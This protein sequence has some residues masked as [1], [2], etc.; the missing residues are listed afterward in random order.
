[1]DRLEGTFGKFGLS[2]FFDRL[3]KSGV[4]SPGVLLELLRG[5]SLV[6]LYPMVMGV[7]AEIPVGLDQFQVA[8]TKVAELAARVPDSEYPDLADGL[9]VG[10]RPGSAQL[11]RTG[12]KGPS[13]LTLWSPRVGLRKKARFIEVADVEADD[14]TRI[15]SWRFIQILMKGDAPVIAE[16]AEISDKE[17]FLRGL[18]G[19]ARLSTL[20]LRVRVWETFQRWLVWKGL[21]PWP[22]SVGVVM[23]YL[24]YR[25]EEEPVRTFPAC[26]LAT[27]NWIELR[28]GYPQGQRLGENEGL[29]QNFA[30]AIKDAETDVVVRKKAVRF[31]L[32]VVGGME[33]AVVDESVPV[34]ARILLWVRLMK[35]YGVL[36][37]DDVQWMGPKNLTMQETGLAGILTQTKTTGAGKKVKELELFVPAEA[38]ITGKDWLKVGYGLLQAEVTF[39]RDYLIPRAT[40][41]W[42]GFYTSRATPRDMA[43]MYLGALKFVK[44]PGGAADLLGEILP[45]WSGHSERCTLTSNL[46]AMGRPKSERDVLGRWS[47]EGSDDYVRSYRA[48]VRRLVLMFV[49][50]ARCADSYKALDEDNTYAD[51]ERRLVMRHGEQEGI[52]TL[53]QNL[54]KAAKEFAVKN[55]QAD[56]VRKPDVPEEAAAQLVKELTDAHDESGDQECVEGFILAVTQK[57]KRATCLHR[58]GGCWRARSLAFRDY[59]VVE[60]GPPESHLYDRFCRVCWP[61]SD[62]RGG[63]SEASSSGTSSSSARTP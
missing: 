2:E 54:I 1:M 25:L 60:G 15:W 31:P 19:R 22:E 8:V 27:L 57:K 9:V 55:A 14:G 53:V 44:L 33:E 18:V 4:T 24:W 46:A 37:A 40:P 62:P 20:K 21:R 7:D 32:L 41:D 29:R 36:R 26:F 43:A 17:R 12:A 13:A 39:E 35:V 47:P 23:D 30:Q 45:V 50:A 5:Q 10:S 51:I 48:M 52:K 11:P 49:R 3:G 56:V 34:A 16:L 38:S 61:A 42:G 6:A 58:G 59:E 63:G 28:A